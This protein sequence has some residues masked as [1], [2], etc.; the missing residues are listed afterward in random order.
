MSGAE[1]TQS[2]PRRGRP[3]GNRRALILREA[4]RLFHEH[5]FHGTSIIQIGAAAGVKGPTVY[6]HFPDKNAVLVALIEQSAERSEAEIA[7][8]DREGG[9][10][11][12]V[13]ERLVHAQV[14]QAIDDGPLSAVAAREVR[15]L[16]PETSEPLLRRGRANF[17]EWVSRI[18][19]ARP[20]LTADEARTLTAGAKWLIFTVATGHAGLDDQL[21]YRLIVRMTLGL[22]L[23][24]RP[25]RAPAT[26][27]TRSPLAGGDRRELI[28]REAARLFVE[29]G[30][31]ATGMDEIGEAV[32]VTGPALYHHV[33]GKDELLLAILR[34]EADRAEAEV[35]ETYRVDGPAGQLL[36]ALVRTRVRRAL[37]DAHLMAVVDRESH[38]LPPS[39]RQA[40][41][42][43][44]R[45]NREEWVHLIAESRPDLCDA[46]VRAM[47]DGVRALI[48]GLVTSGTSLVGDRLEAVALDAALAVLFPREDAAG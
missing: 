3:P 29:K 1:E 35:A 26:A 27:V 14:R 44:Q 41:L 37:T 48:F 28:I 21:L 7:R 9:S 36:E 22:L 12:E 25:F 13:L 47:V 46:E 30:Y 2:R 43:S 11:R 42:R 32:G 33:N 38:S 31:H 15:S 5:G 20:E 23:P 24:E 39:R 40:V 34:A 19:G 6:R 16:S 10:P 17:Q 4:A 18:V 8:I 45:I